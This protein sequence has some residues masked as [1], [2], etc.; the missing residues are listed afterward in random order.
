MEEFKAV[1]ECLEWIMVELEERAPWNDKCL[2]ICV[3]DYQETGEVEYTVYSINLKD[4]L[5]SYD[6]SQIGLNVVFKVP[7]SIMRAC[8]GFGLGFGGSTVFI[9]GGFR[10]TRFKELVVPGCYYDVQ[11]YKIS[12]RRWE[13]ILFPPFRNGKVWPL[14]WEV[15][16][17]LFALTT[18]PPPALPWS[19][20]VASEWNL[21]FE[22][23]DRTIGSWILLP[24]PPPYSCPGDFSAFS[25]AILGSQLFV[26]NPLHPDYTYKCNLSDLSR[27]QPLKWQVSSFR[28]RGATL[29]VC[30]DEGHFVVFSHDVRGPD[31]PLYV[32]K[33]EDDPYFYI[34]VDL[35][36][37]GSDESIMAPHSL[38][39]GHGLHEIDECQFVHL[40][41][42]KVTFL[43]STR[44]GFKLSVMAIV[45][46]FQ[47][48][49]TDDSFKLH[50]KFH[51]TRVWH[52]DNEEGSS[53]IAQIVNAVVCK[54]SIFFL[55]PTMVG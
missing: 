18:K 21:C 49:K 4:M 25:H 12:D 29:G 10:A 37:H 13:E 11:A 43:C 3:A 52:F 47:L 38:F 1:D 45:F 32:V 20:V 50:T 2:Y 35:L 42:Q 17:N 9:A 44:V 30:T 53:G 54:F 6:S 7:K 24:N 55:Y 22:M 40:G 36:E 14:I 26:S 51:P 39:V 5:F 46:D 23:Y 8:A 41:G 16:E 31:L 33:E 15:E 48:E 27:K 34:T 19:D 28:F